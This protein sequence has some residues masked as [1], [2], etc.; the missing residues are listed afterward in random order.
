[1]GSAGHLRKIQQDQDKGQA[2]KHLIHTFKHPRG[3]VRK[4][5]VH[6][7]M[8]FH[9]PR[10]NF[11]PA[12][13]SQRACCYL[14]PISQVCFSGCVNHP[15]DLNSEGTKGYQVN[16]LL[17]PQV[18]RIP[19][20]LTQLQGL[21]SA[22]GPQGEESKTRLSTSTALMKAV[23][24]RRRSRWLGSGQHAQGQ[25]NKQPTFIRWG[26][27]LPHAA[28]LDHS[29]GGEPLPQALGGAHCGE[30]PP[31][32]TAGRHLPSVPQQ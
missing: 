28:I 13:A 29:E 5:Y 18:L 15:P 1:M 25:Q 19:A 2:A 27:T 4:S 11:R 21:R 9:P 23:R 31:S 8:N 6:S 26:C 12:P 7:A 10:S 20:Q 32:T 3:R 30:A 24:Q 14:K 16:M 22:G 17:L